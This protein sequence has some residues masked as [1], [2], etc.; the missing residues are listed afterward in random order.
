MARRVLRAA[1]RPGRAERMIR[2]TLT[3]APHPAAYDERDLTRLLQDEWRTRRRLYPRRLV[4]VENV[5]PSSPG[6]AGDSNG[7]S[8]SG[9]PAPRS[10][11]GQS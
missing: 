4:D 11:R 2:R 3:G 1:V 10:T 5:V 6:I 8:V 9:W 7:G